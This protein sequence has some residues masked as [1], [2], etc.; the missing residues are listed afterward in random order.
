MATT[1]PDHGPN[2]F[3]DVMRKA[4]NRPQVG[5]QDETSTTALELLK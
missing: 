4:G 1:L 5:D 3:S 2:N